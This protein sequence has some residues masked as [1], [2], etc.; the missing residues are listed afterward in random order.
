MSYQQNNFILTFILFCLLVLL[1]GKPAKADL[2]PLI[3]KPY[4]CTVDLI[5]K[6][7]SKP[8]EYKLIQSIERYPY[9]FIYRIPFKQEE[10]RPKD[11]TSSNN[12]YVIYLNILGCSKPFIKII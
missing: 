8:I 2:V 4:G 11:V 5:K 10:V 6:D 9:P 1:G 7:P 12:K 3:Y